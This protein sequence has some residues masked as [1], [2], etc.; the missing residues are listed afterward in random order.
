VKGIEIKEMP[1]DVAKAVLAAKKA[2]LCALLRD[3]RTARSK[4]KPYV[5]EERAFVLLFSAE[6]YLC[7]AIRELTLG[8]IPQS[9][10]Y[11]QRAMGALQSLLPPK[12]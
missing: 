8:N 6:E 2:Q 5:W 11:E 7:Q 12:E 10:I 4:L 9:Q 1:C 3:V